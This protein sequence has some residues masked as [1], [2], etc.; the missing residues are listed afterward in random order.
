MEGRRA[1]ETLGF[2]KEM[3]GY[4]LLG[5][6]PGIFSDQEIQVIGMNMEGIRIKL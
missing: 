3:I 4:R 2:E 5:C 1:Q 6:H